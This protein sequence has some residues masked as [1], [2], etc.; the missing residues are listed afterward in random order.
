[1]SNRSTIGNVALADIAE[2]AR[3]LQLQGIERR[4]RQRRRIGG[5]FADSRACCPRPD[6]RLHASALDLVDVDA[7]AFG[8]GSLQ[9][10][11]R[12]GADLAH[13]LDEVADAARAVGVLVAVGLFVARR[14]H[15]AHA[16]P[17]GVESRRRRSSAATCERRRYPFRR[18]AAT[19]V[20]MPS[21]SIET[22]MCGLVTTPCGIFSAPVGIG[23]GGA[24]RRELRGKNEHAGAGDALEQLAAADIG[25]SD[26]CVGCDDRSCQAPFDALR[27]AVWMR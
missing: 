3:L 7:P 2:G 14:L 16:R 20:T 12:A 23:H 4:C 24:N 25:E 26:V 11:A 22:K 18:G 6:A 17:V 13:R 15:D 10:L 19:M 21:L 8:S 1:M 5:E 9:H 27:T